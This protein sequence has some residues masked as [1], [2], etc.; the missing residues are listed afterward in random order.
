MTEL[1]AAHAVDGAR[2]DLEA[3]DAAD[4]EIA[5]AV[6]QAKADVAETEPAEPTEPDAAAE[7]ARKAGIAALAGAVA[8]GL[9]RGRF[10]DVGRASC[11]LAE[12]YGVARPLDCACA[13]LLSQSCTC[14]LYTSPSPRDGL[15]S[16][17]PSSA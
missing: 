1:D 10:D 2:S 8:F 3:N 5:A 16:R 7:A 6:A 17:M 15:L 4:A 14:L 11:A 13:L 12:T 9:K